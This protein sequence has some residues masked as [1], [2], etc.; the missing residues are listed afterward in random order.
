MIFLTRFLSLASG[1]LAGQSG[2]TCSQTSGTGTCKVNARKHSDPY[3]EP[4]F[5]DTVGFLVPARSKRKR[6]KQD[7]E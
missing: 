4:V 7:S 1:Y 2:F 5:L 3:G 6:I